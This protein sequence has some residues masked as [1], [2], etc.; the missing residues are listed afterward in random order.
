LLR[1]EEKLRGRIEGEG[2]GDLGS[3]KGAADNKLLGGVV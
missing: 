3:D 2:E 1:D